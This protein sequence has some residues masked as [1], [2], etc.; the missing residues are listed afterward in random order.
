MRRGKYIIGDR[1]CPILLVSSLLSSALDFVG[2]SSRKKTWIKGV[3][4]GLVIDGKIRERQLI[5]W[6]M[7]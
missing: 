2:V 6:N 3:K 1:F 5:I 7:E 4:F